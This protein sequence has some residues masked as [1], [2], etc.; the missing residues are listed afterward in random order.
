MRAPKSLTRD[1][2][3]ALLQAASVNAEHR[4]MLTTSYTHALRV[5]ELC[6]LTAANVVDGF[7]HITR[8]KGSED[9]VQAASPELQAWAKAH[10]TGPLF[11][12]EYSEKCRRWQVRRIYQRYAVQA[13]IPEH[14][15]TGTHV[16]RHSCATLMLS[17][18]AALNDVAVRLGHKSVTSTA[19]YTRSNDASG[20]KAFAACAA[21]ESL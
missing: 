12:A 8:K 10:P 14:K 3:K 4:L 18:K 17:G 9:G 20:D 21:L 13:A 7:L 1:E 2:L 6:L 5:S 11:L 16:L 19:I 15:L